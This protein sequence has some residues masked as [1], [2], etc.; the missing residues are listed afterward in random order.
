VG[1]RYWRR[2]QVLPGIRVNLSLSGPS[3]SVGHRGLWF[4]TGPAGRR[5]TVGLPGSGLRWTQASGKPRQPAPSALVGLVWL[6]V[7]AL[8][9]WVLLR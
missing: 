9:L 1:L 5:A 2:F 3:I 7:I 6:A 8:V 4:T